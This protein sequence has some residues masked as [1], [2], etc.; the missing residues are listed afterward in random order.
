MKTD[1]VGA[2]VI[3]VVTMTVVLAATFVAAK[4]II[5]ARNGPQPVC[6]G[7]TPQ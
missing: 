7:A 1:W 5:G 2:I 3:L 4:H 6:E